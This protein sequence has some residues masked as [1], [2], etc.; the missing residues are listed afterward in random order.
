M[1]E[2]EA[3]NHLL[4]WLGLPRT[5]ARHV[6]RTG[7]AGTA[8]RQ[9]DGGLGYDSEEVDALTRRSI[10]DEEGDLRDVAPSGIAIARLRPGRPW[11]TNWCG[12]G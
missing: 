10:L 4:V 11:S 3:A 6:L 8:Q 1:T 7:I 2:G 12:S 9:P 5:S